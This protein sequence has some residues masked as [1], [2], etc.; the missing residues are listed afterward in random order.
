MNQM[1]PVEILPGKT[2]YPEGSVL[3]L[4]L[5]KNLDSRLLVKIVMFQEVL[6]FVPFNIENTM[7][8]PA[9]ILEYYNPILIGDKTDFEYFERFIVTHYPQI[10]IELWDRICQLWAEK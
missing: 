2:A 3:V 1:R 6:S 5:D 8:L 7:P 9:S 4:Q 10:N